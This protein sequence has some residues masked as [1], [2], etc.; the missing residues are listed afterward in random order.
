MTRIKAR[1]LAAVLTLAG[2]LAVTP[3]LRA[4][5]AAEAGKA[6]FERG[7]KQYNLGRFPEAIVEF[8]HA[9][10]KD[11]APILLFNIAQSHRQHGNKERALFFYRRYLEQA[12]DAPNRADVEQRQKESRAVASAREGAEAEATHGGRLGEWAGRRGREPL[13]RVVAAH[14][15]PERGDHLRT[16][17]R[18][19]AVV[20]GGLRGAFVRGRLGAGRGGAGDVRG[21]P[22]RGVR[23]S[24]G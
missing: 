5:T 9:Y 20:G 23:I 22:G 21:A 2:L 10:D 7:V 3:A 14:P 19:G 13:R 6:H 1:I 4:E 16:V 12:P 15:D 8:E 24:A 17:V 11:P 18:D